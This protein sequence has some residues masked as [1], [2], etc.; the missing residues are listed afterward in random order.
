M[1]LWMVP[2]LAREFTHLFQLR[3]IPAIVALVRRTDILRRPVFFLGPLGALASRRH[4]RTKRQR[5]KNGRQDALLSLSLRGL[6]RD[7]LKRHMTITV[8]DDVESTHATSDG[9]RL[10][11]FRS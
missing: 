6:A 4:L 7:L 11:F 2:V 10:K 8:E 5:I 1:R 9:Q 3:L